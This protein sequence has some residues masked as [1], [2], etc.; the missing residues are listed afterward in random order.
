MAQLRRRA[1]KSTA[2]ESPSLPYEPAAPTHDPTPETPV[3]FADLYRMGASTPF[4]WQTTT[5]TRLYRL[6]GPRDGPFEYP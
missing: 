5:R 1:C 4:R 3:I 6:P 2:S